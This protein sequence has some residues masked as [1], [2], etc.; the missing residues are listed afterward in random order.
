MIGFHAKTRRAEKHQVIAC[1]LT[2]NEVGDTT[3]VP[4]LLGQIRAGFK[5][6][7][8]DG[9]YDGQPTYDAVLAVQSDAEII[10]PPRENA[11]CSDGGQ[12]QRDAHIQFI[13]GNGRLAWQQETNYGLRSYVE[14]AMQRFK[15]IFGNTLKARKLPQQLT[16]ARIASSALNIM[17]SLGMPVSVKC[18]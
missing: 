11:L 15:R 7:L 14:L 4:G 12:S 10:I 1:D 13:Q 8:G 9:A 5:Q 2:T 6:L 17:T 16:E 18:I 3:A